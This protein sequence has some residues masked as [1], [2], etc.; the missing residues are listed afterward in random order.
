MIN[1]FSTILLVISLSFFVLY[2]YLI[3]KSTNRVSKIFSFVCLSVAIYVIGYR[4]ELQSNSIEEIKFFLKMEYFGQPFM[5]AFW[6]MFIYNFY[7]NRS[8]SLRLSILFFAIP[9]LTLF[10]SATNEYHHLLYANISAVHYNG[11]I[12]AKL[13]KG[14][15]YYVHMLYGYTSLILGLVYFFKAWLN[16]RNKRRIQYLLLLFGT[17]SPGIIEVFYFTGLSP[18]GLDL[19]PFSFSIMAVCYYIALFHYDF[20]EFDEIIHKVIFSKISEGIIV[21]DYKNRLI[22]YNKSARKVFDWLN[23]SNIGINI[24]ELTEAKE[25]IEH[26]E[27]LFEI[28]A[29]Q[30]N[31]HKYFE[32]HVTKLSDKNKMLGSIYFIRDITQQKEL[33]HELDDLASYDQLTHVYNRRRLMEEAEKEVSRVKRYNCP[34][35]FL[36]I[37]IDLFKEVNDKY[38]HLAGD[39]VIQS[40]AAACSERIR[41]TDIVGRYGGEEFA[42]LLPFTNIDNAKILAEHIRKYIEDMEITYLENKIQVTVS[43]GVAEAASNKAQEIDFYYL[44]NKAD[45]ALYRSKNGGRNRIMAEI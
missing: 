11:F 39:K 25:I 21:L 10:F 19:L 2:I 38:G 24:A 28:E 35:S 40:V 5:F 13:T 8:P 41:S 37:D 43:I 30:N 7:F 33:I 14:P 3:S 27:D 44:L 29:V 12:V 1:A 34:L 42:V 26:K 32:F 16:S 6:L 36:M 31:I 23:S 22:D 45:M 9:I 18:Y 4:F 15:W 17:F 20:I